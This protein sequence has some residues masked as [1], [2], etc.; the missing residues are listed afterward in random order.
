MKIKEYPINQVNPL[1]FF[2][3]I[4]NQSKYYNDLEFMC[5]KLIDW[6]KNTDHDAFLQT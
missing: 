6:D 4:L 3:L 5:L 1:I 2:K